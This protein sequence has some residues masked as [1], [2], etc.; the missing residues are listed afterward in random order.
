MVNEYDP[1]TE[2]YQLS[3]PL[4]MGGKLKIPSPRLSSLES[5]IIRSE[6]LKEFHSVNVATTDFYGLAK[7]IVVNNIERSLL[8]TQGA[9]IKDSIVR[10]R[11]GIPSRNQLRKYMNDETYLVRYLPGLHLA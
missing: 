2:A 3:D 6:A 5:C 9:Y 4:P 11:G 8:L 7:R 1:E 10:Q